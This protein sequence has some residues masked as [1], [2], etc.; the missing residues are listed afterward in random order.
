MSDNLIAC[1]QCVHFITVETQHC[2]A[3]MQRILIKKYDYPIP[4]EL[5][6]PCKKCVIAL[7]CTR[8]CSERGEYYHA[9]DTIVHNILDKKRNESNRV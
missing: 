6:C 5:V 4:S 2:L 8:Y 1:G 3:L 9:L 7:S